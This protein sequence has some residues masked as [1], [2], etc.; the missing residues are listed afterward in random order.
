[1]RENRFEH[2]TAHEDAEFVSYPSAIRLGLSTSF[3][4]V[5]VT[6]NPNKLKEVR[7]ILSQGGNPISIESQNLDSMS[8][9][10]LFFWGFPELVYEFPVP[11]I[12][13]TTV[14]VASAKCRR[15]AELVGGPCI[16]E[17]TALCYEALNGLPGPYIKYFLTDIGHDGLNRLL[18]GFESKKAEALCTFAY[19]SG[20]GEQGSLEKAFFL[21][22]FRC[23]SNHF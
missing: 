12:Q 23:Q 13:G 15:A 4:I 18:V 19:S 11:E 10:P 7:E 17:D 2:V 9:L 8:S 21:T 20:P 6:G 14:E 3:S 22:R 16:T 1:M 5:F